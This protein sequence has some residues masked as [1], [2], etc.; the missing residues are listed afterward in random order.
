MESIFLISILIVLSLIFII[1]SIYQRGLAKDYKQLCKIKD[2]IIAGDKKLISYYKEKNKK[3]NATMKNMTLIKPIRAY[4]E[5]VYIRECGVYIAT[6]DVE[7]HDFIE[8]NIEKF[9]N[10]LTDALYR[11]D[12]KLCKISISKVRI[13][14][15]GESK[16]DNYKKE[17]E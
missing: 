10:D 12:G 3:L 4:Y 14:K 13:L 5:N 9:S 6:Y 2:D 7:F 11:K 16:P 8:I 1:S 15:D 17:L